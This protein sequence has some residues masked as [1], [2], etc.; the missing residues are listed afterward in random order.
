MQKNYLHVSSIMK[1]LVNSIK[2]REDYLE[3][4]NWCFK[5]KIGV[6]RGKRMKLSYDITIG[7]I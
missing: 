6:L 3:G 7:F 1:V 5:G 2:G 4:E